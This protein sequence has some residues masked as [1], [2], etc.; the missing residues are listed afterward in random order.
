MVIQVHMSLLFHGIKSAMKFFAIS[1]SGQPQTKACPALAAG[2][3]ST[4]ERETVEVPSWFFTSRLW[5]RGFLN[6]RLWIWTLC[7]Y[8]VV[9][10]QFWKLRTFSMHANCEWFTKSKKQLYEDVYFH[11]FAWTCSL[12]PALLPPLY[13]ILSGCQSPFLLICSVCILTF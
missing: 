6:L 1:L 12:E 11:L 2:A 10:S 8:Q 7:C 9:Y 13:G 5:L 3:G 4:Y